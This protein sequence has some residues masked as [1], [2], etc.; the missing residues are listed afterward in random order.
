MGGHA[1]DRVSTRRYDDAEYRVL[2]E[3][4]KMELDKLFGMPLHFV[5]A[6]FEKESHGDM[7]IMLLND[8]KLGNMKDK[9][10]AH[11]KPGQIYCNG[12]VYSFDYKELQIDIIFTT[13]DNWET[14]KVFFDFDPSGNLMG[15]IAHKFGLKYGFKGLV[16]PYR[17]PAGIELADITVSKDND[18]IFKF[19]GFDFQIF[20][21]GF[22]TKVEIFDY[23]INSKHF[24]PQNFMMENLNHI[25]K[26]RNRKRPTY[27]EFLEYINRL[28]N[29]NDVKRQWK[30]TFESNKSVYLPVIASAF[31]EARIY[32]K[33]QDCLDADERHRRRSEIFNGEIVKNMFPGLS[34]E[35]L[36]KFIVGFKKH[37]A[38]FYYEEARQAEMAGRQ[39]PAYTTMS[40]EELFTIYLDTVGD[41]E[42]LKKHLL[43]F[44]S[45][46]SC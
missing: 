33:I 12:N 46:P 4:L 39:K 27:Q 28:V 2:Q 18:R 16:Y 21:A 26:K 38:N 17:N 45:K 25:D 7:D 23:V 37:V 20:K 19:L 8:G 43:S 40:N 32:G 24:D 11:F 30:D 34:G 35:Q 31:P 42:T 6:Y 29:E 3:E 13:P 15:K 10:E 14:S 9:I 22:K 41:L 36:G 5:N 44:Y 1:L